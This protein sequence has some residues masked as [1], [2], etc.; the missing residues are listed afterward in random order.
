MSVGAPSA[1]QWVVKSVLTWVGVV[2]MLAGGGALRYAL[3]DGFFTPITPVSPTCRNIAEGINGTNDFAVD[4]VHN[5]LL[6]SANDRRAGASG[7]QSGIYF[8]KLTDLGAAPVKL[9]GTP[10]NFQPG[11]LSLFRAQDGSET[12]TLIDHKPGGRDMLE[13]YGID[14]DG[15]TAKLNQQ[16]A[17]QSRLLISPN[18]VTTVAPEHFYVT[19][20]HVST[21]TLGRFA[22]DYLLW[23]HADVLLSSGA[24][25][26]I[27]AQRIAFPGGAL[28]KSGFL[29]VAAANERRIIALGIQ[30]FTGNLNEI[31]ALSLPARPGH[32]SMDTAGNLIVAGQSKPGS[33]QVFRIRLD[34]KG[35]PV[36]SETI[37]SDDGHTLKG[38]SAAAVWNGEL[39]IAAADDEKMLACN[40]K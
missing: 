6:I 13:V 12:L 25:F 8:L 26:R 15:Q 30:D 38:A 16:T 17:I 3:V 2:V 21:S 24:G 5:A 39:F 31:G 1:A 22:E 29:Y 36:S 32:I 11:G 34:E 40:L 33:S 28:A 10:A 19:N 14:S 37:F 4:V 7:S 27:A 18:D 35:V 20:D 23:P 9:A